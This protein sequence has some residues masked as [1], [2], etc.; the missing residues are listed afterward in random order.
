MAIVHHEGYQSR[1][2]FPLGNYDDLLAFALNTC[3]G[4]A[5]QLV[6]AFS[7]HQNESELAVDALWK[8]H[9]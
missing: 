6:G 8:F 1:A 9:D 2:N 5:N 4:P 7:S 3:F